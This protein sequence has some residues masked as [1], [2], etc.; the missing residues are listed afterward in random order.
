MTADI[1]ADV[2]IIGSGISGAL[3][4]ARLTAAGVKVA[5]LEA[6]SPVDRST[7][8]ENFWNAVIKV[9]E[10]PYPPT[11]QAMHP[12]SSDMDFWYKQAGTDKFQ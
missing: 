9:P 4:G 1:S 6:G 7:A 8:V 10:C 2:I 5:I 11:P 12:I 3:M